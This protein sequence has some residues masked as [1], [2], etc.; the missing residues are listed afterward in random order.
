MSLF[1]LLRFWDSPG[2]GDNVMAD[3]CYA[4]E[5]IEMLYSDCTLEEQQYG[6]IDMVMV[7][8]DGSGRDMGTT[9]KLLN[10]VILPNFQ[11]NR[12]LVAINQA[13]MAMKGRHWDNSKNCPDEM[14]RNFLENKANSIQ[15]R[16]KEA[17]GITIVKPV[18]YSAE[19]EFN[20][21]QLLDFII[22]H[23]PTERR[24]LVK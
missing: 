4:E 5:L 23:M 11:A 24:N 3:K 15:Q 7:I 22:N 14:L 19:K 17:T 16:I 1:L 9:Y 13:D 20:V 8:L 21:K 18:Y 2:L 10:D 12:I 6:L